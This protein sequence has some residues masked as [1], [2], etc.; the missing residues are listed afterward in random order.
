L[1]DPLLALVRSDPDEAVRAAALKTL[2]KIDDPKLAAPLIEVHN[3]SSSEA[4]KFQIRDVLLRRRESAL[5]WIQAVDRG[6]IAASVT[7][8]EQIRRAALFSDPELDRLVLKHWGKLEWTTRG[9]A[10]A[11]VR[12]LGNDLRAGPGDPVNGRVMFAK[13]CA[14]CHQLFGEGK[15]VGPE[16]TT[17]NRGDA[18]A[19]LVSLVAPSSVI[20]KE[21]VSLVVET[22]DG[23]VLTGLPINQN[24]AGVTLADNKGDTIEIATGDIEAI[25]ESNVSLM[26]Q[27]L[28]RTMTPQQLRDLFAWIQSEGPTQ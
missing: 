20:R 8:I 5:V 28:Y 25:R 16:L 2:A 18:I 15:K 12:R 10:L 7:P 4:F 19:L 11:E 21:Y 26:P 14:T 3:A 24:A 13:H 9:E 1:C 6:E 22:S 17:A 27:G 23:R